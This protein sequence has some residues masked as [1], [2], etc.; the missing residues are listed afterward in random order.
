MTKKFQLPSLE[1]EGNRKFKFVT[2]FLKHYPKQFKQQ[3]KNFNHQINGN[4]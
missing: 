3:P 4:Y 2:K 1:I